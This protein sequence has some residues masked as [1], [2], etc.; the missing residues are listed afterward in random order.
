[1]HAITAGSK[2]RS[3]GTSDHT[4]FA[5]AWLS[6]SAAGSPRARSCSTI[7]LAT[8]YLPVPGNPSSW[9]TAGTPCSMVD[10]FGVTAASHQRDLDEGARHAHPNDRSARRRT[11]LDR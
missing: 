8:V 2:R 3:S 10:E 5:V 7:A 9:Y 4:R 11:L 1:M 6:I